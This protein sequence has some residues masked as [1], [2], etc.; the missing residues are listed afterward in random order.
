M[1][2]RQ[3]SYLELF[4]PKGKPGRLKPEDGTGWR[5]PIPVSAIT[6]LDRRRPKL[7]ILSIVVLLYM[8][9]LAQLRAYTK[10]PNM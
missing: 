4:I 10:L 9:I 7:L 6:T 8:N 1:P 2:G 3:H 5:G